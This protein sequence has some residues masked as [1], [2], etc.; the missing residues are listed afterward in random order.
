[1]TDPSRRTLLCGTAGLLVV[2]AGCLDDAGL[3]SSDDNGADTDGDDETTSEDTA[4]D[5]D[6]TYD[7]VSFSH[8][9]V[10]TEPDATL[11]SS[12][13]RAERWLDAREFDDEQPTEFVDDTDFE[14][15][16]LLALEA[17]AP[18][19][20]YELALETVTVAHEDDSEPGLVVAA[21]VREISSGSEGFGGTQLITVGQLV[22]A[23]FDG[24]PVPNAA[25]TIV[26]SDGQE[27][28]IATAA[29]TASER[30][31]GTANETA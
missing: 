11:L 19:L 6:D 21:T 15:S 28:S 30:D 7:T 31:D 25:V 17:D 20:D 14:E 26:D 3:A 13:T 1:M 29:D 16:A 9:D 8:A 5:E 22:R 2:A 10:P 12:S 18:R 23:T 4:S 24:E 27:H